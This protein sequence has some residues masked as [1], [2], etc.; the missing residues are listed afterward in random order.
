MRGYHRRRSALSTTIWAGAFLTLC[1]IL[2]WKFE[3]LPGSGSES[4]V[5]EGV[6][7][8]DGLQV[9][10]Q[11]AD[12][13]G[14]GDQTPAA[15]NPF[16]FE[17]QSEPGGLTSQDYNM[18]RKFEPPVPGA[19]KNTLIIPKG[20]EPRP[21]ASTGHPLAES[22]DPGRSPYALRPRT[23]PNGIQQTGFQKTQID[24]SAPPVAT[25]RRI[26]GLIRA[27][28]LL[29]AHKELS[30][31]HWKHPEWRGAIR[32]RIEMTAKSIYFQNQQHY[33]TP[34]IVR[35]NDQLRLIARKYGVSWQYLE[36]LNGTT[37][38]GIRP[39][40]KLK[41]IKGPFHAVVDLSDREITVH[42]YGYFVCKYPIG[43]GKDGK[44]PLGKRTVGQKDINPRYEGRDDRG[45]LI[46]IEADD[47]KNPLGERWISLGNSYGIHGTIDPKSI[48]RAESKGCIRMHNRDVEVV[49]DFLTVGSEVLIQR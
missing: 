46:Q 32:T 3:W 25:L 26:D 6:E 45:R 37:A 41:V 16:V 47:P 39:G 9:K 14:T 36:R 8:G 7:A 12:K 1:L 48:G 49:F 33:L 20:G 24:T 44:T 29:D 31:I 17:K 2:A 23:Q 43:I 42:H 22:N 40:D 15:D 11:P 28:K 27:D 5:E 38:R 13:S 34:Y 30:E 10:V 19:T 4:P 18:P 21:L 35:P